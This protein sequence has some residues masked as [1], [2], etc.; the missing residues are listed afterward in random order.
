MIKK[1]KIVEKVLSNPSI[2]E[3]CKLL[4]KEGQKILTSPVKD[5]F[6]DNTG[7]TKIETRN[8]IYWCYENSADCQHCDMICVHRDAYRRLP[9][10]VGGLALCAKL[11]GGM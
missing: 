11:K 3:P 8:T 6:T 1:E 2:G 5:F 9:R 10:E 4:T 7:A